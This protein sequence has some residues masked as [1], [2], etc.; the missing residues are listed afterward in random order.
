MKACTVSGA[1]RLEIVDLEPVAR[2]APHEVRIAYATGGI[3]GS[4]LHYYFHGG[5]GNF[6]LR[7]PLILGHEVAGTVTEV[8]DA[9]GAVRVG[10]G[11]AV[12]PNLPCL[13]CRECLSGLTNLCREMTFFGSAAVMPHVQGGWR[14]ELVV[15]ER[16]AVGL[17][18]GTDL[19]LAAFAEP[20]AICLHA[21]NRAGPIAHREVLVTGCGPIGC[22]AVAA[23]KLA[24]AGRIVATDV[25]GGVLEHARAL[26]ADETID[27]SAEPE[28]LAALREG[29]GTLDAAIECSGAPAALAT[30]IE[31]VRPRGAIVQ[32]GMLPAGDNPIPA[33]RI[34]AKE[35]TLT[36]TFR[37]HDEFRVAVDALVRG[38]IDP[39]ALLTGTFDFADADA[40]FEA[41]RDRTRH[42]KVQLRFGADRAPPPA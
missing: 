31:S 30:C 39:S 19:A 26:G 11:V 40:A 5:V 7:E 25:A 29:R 2:L 35:L 42:M 1:K 9:V 15:P 21:V 10:Q 13:A 17:P 4:D 12:D 3:C 23:L 6:T 20:L 28:R 8:G 37:F 24:G 38:R 14:E 34:V 27:S 18:D 16:Q 32:T 22:L 33:N 36:G 41:A